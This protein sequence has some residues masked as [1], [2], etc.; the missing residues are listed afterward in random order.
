MASSIAT[1]KSFPDKEEKLELI[2]TPCGL[3]LPIVSDVSPS[4]TDLGKVAIP[5]SLVPDSAMRALTRLLEHPETVGLAAYEL[6]RESEGLFLN[7]EV[8]MP[9]ASVVKVVE[10]VAYAEAV[11]EGRIDPAA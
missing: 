10:L 2:Q 9:L 3:L 4:S 5:D 1:P 7:A 6:G 8:P 11:N